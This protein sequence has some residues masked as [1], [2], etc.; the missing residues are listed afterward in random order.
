VSEHDKKLLTVAAARKSLQI[1]GD[2][3]DAHRRQ[4]AKAHLATKQRHAHSAA[5]HPALHALSHAYKGVGGSETQ[6]A[7][8]SAQWI[9]SRTAPPIHYVD[10]AKGPTS[11]GDTHI[12]GSSSA[13]ASA[14]LRSGTHHASMSARFEAVRH[15]SLSL[16]HLGEKHSQIYANA[17]DENA[18]HAVESLP[19]ML[20]PLGCVTLLVVFAGSYYVKRKQRIPSGLDAARHQDFQEIRRGLGKSAE[21]RSE[22]RELGS[23]V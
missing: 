6:Q 21:N 3:E 14:Q 13:R 23:T 16:A 8:S 22:W 11:S 7:T 20:P 17:A 18:H 4:V 10:A 15:K 1:D 2:E 12:G 19:Y 9:D 5:L